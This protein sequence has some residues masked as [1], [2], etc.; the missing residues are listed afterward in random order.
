[1]FRSSNLA[2]DP[3]IPAFP[4]GI[5]VW[6][7]P[8][9]AEVDIVFIH[10]LTGDRERTWTHPSASQPWPM[11]LLPL[12]LPNSRIL[13]FGYDAYVVQRGVAA[14][15]QLVDHSRDLLNALT[16]LR[17]MT[18]TSTRHLILVGHSLGGLICKDAILQSRN[19]PEPHLRNIF[20]TVKA[21]AFLG[22]PHGGSDLASW[23][24]IP[25]KALGVAKSVNTD[26]L[27][28][29]QTSSEVL[30]R[31]QTDFLSMVRDLR[32]QDRLIKMACYW[33][34]LPMPGI[35]IIVPRSSASLAGYNSISVH[36]NHKDMVKFSAAEDPGFMSLVGELMRWVRELGHPSQTAGTP[37]VIAKMLDKQKEDCLKSLRFQEYD[38]RKS[39]IV[40]PSSG[41]CNWIFNDSRYVSW[42]LPKY[43]PESASILW[44]KGKP[45]SG[46]SILMKNI[47]LCQERSVLEGDAICISFF[48]NGRGAEIERSPLGL[49]QSLLFQ[50]L[51]S[52]DALMTEF[53]PNYIRKE[54]QSF[55]EK[56]TW[57]THEL[58]KFFH[59]AIIEMKSTSIYI[60]VDALDEC[61]EDDVRTIIRD[62]EDTSAAAV[63]NGSVVKICLSSRHFPQISLRNVTSQEIF[64]ESS[65]FEDIRH[66]VHRELILE[67]SDLRNGL[68]AG[69]LNRSHGVFL[70]TSFIVRR[71]LKAS[72][73]GYSAEQMTKLLDSIPS[74]LEGL[75]EQ[76]LI[77]LEPLRLASMAL[78]APWVICSLRPLELDE[79]YQILAF[80][81]EIPP[82]SLPKPVIRNESDFKRFRRQLTDSS[83][84]LFEVQ[85][86]VQVIHE[87]VRD[88]FMKSK[89]VAE[90]MRLPSGKGFI[91]YSHEQITSAIFH[92][93]AVREMRYPLPPPEP[94]GQIA[95]SKLVAMLSK[96]VLTN[97]K[98]IARCGITYFHTFAFAHMKERLKIS[99]ATLIDCGTP[100]CKSPRAILEG[101]LVFLYY[102]VIQTGRIS[103]EQDQIFDLLYQDSSLVQLS[104]QQLQRIITSINNLVIFVNKTMKDG[105][106]LDSSSI[107]MRQDTSFNGEAPTYLRLFG[108]Q[109]MRWKPDLLTKYEELRTRLL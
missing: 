16:A 37:D 81:T 87:S 100:A 71:L 3:I 1:M 93:F 44:I 74:S 99:G 12:H 109:R 36:A 76:I 86:K 11:S 96:P 97:F 90:I 6:H 30:Y 25:V 78:L 70:W 55:G 40:N 62:F 64:L 102:S 53:L 68:I 105:F 49:Y 58:S 18:D 103:T 84:G 82:L 2:K 48:F 54:Q 35:G 31:I 75:F 106:V 57:Q 20:L 8:S 34:S 39:T 73:Q 9:E 33:E 80:N 72:D 108:D 89:K 66:F 56:I 83:G 91:E 98:S 101:W 61:D 32:E 38:S 94:N 69:I 43:H 85:F 29:L 24:Q 5:K 95:V 26:L 28:V 14:S 50:L 46:K 21:I 107:T 23:A 42:T 104:T 60:F 67:P 52:S 77:D 15:N 47:L 19:N 51:Q 22:T 13:A 10:G 45:G 4:Q 7:N 27:S 63:S 79:I 41:T 65:N 17:D 59:S 92:Y 88:F